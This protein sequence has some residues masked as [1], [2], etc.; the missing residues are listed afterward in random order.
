M[1]LI[2]RLAHNRWVDSLPKEERARNP[3][4]STEGVPKMSWNECQEQLRLTTRT[5]N[6]IHNKFPGKLG[7]AERDRLLPYHRWMCLFIHARLIEIN[8]ER[9]RKDRHQ[10]V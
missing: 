5:M 1:N 3:K 2:E 6:S 4:M 10:S 8:A 7:E 9:H